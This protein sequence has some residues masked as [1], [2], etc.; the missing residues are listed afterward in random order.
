MFTAGRLGLFL[1]C[2]S[3]LYVL[4]FRSILLLLGALILSVPLSFVLLR[5]IRL[6]W[7]AEIERNLERR[8]EAKEKLR[9]ALRGDE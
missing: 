1:V 3:L 5:P 2:A 7:S 8:R 9:S 6:K 4:G